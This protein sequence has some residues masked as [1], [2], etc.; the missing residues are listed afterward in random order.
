MTNAHTQ[1]IDKVL[2]VGNPSAEDILRAVKHF[3]DAWMFDHDPSGIVRDVR[4]LIASSQAAAQ[5]APATGEHA[6]AV[7]TLELIGYTYH[8]GVLWKPPLGPAP[9]FDAPATGDE[10][11]ASGAEAL[12]NLRKELGTIRWMSAVEG[13]PWDQAINAVRARVLEV[14]TGGK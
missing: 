8:G 7:R 12:K 14:I 4:A 11:E 5:P 6:A 1:P 10:R 13:D 9:T 2:P 3:A